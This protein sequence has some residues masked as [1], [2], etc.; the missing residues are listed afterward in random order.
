MYSAYVI[1]FITIISDAIIKFKKNANKKM[2]CLIKF[3]LN[4]WWWIVQENTETFS[5]L[6]LDNINVVR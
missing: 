1:H 5:S 3:V 2:Y 4:N 6:K